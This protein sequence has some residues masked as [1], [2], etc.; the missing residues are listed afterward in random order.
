[1][2]YIH[3]QVWRCHEIDTL[4][5]YARSTF[6]MQIHSNVSNDII[7]FT[8]VSDQNQFAGTLYPG[9]WDLR[10][11]KEIGCCWKPTRFPVSDT[12]QLITRLSRSTAVPKKFDC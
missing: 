7:G 8:K 10:K 6:F 5:G 12:E 3:S 11:R 2:T 4:P 9:T 1:M